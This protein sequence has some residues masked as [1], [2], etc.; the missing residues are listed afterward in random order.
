MKKIFFT[1]A[2]LGIM[3][4][5]V[6]QSEQTLEQN[7][8]GTHVVS[9]SPEDMAKMMTERIHSIVTLTPEQYTKVLEINRATME[10]RKAMIAARQAGQE[11]SE[12]KAAKDNSA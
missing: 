4:V 11:A 2:A 5:C 7:K 8:L 6:A 9:R 3:A 1:V 10:Q 12:T